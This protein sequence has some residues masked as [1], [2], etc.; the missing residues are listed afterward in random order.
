MTVIRILLI[1]LGVWLGWYGISLLLDMNPTDL[2]SVALWFAGGIL[3]HD[4]VF[5]PIAATL[6]VAARRVLPASWWA[7]VACGTV[8]TV[9]LALIAVPVIGRAGALSG[10][11]TILNRDYVLGLSI[12]LAVVWLLVAVALRRVHTTRAKL[13]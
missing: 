11:P 9:T 5:A 1:A 7:P 2:R 10:N 12:S 13:S 8:C 4:G 6:G 3:L